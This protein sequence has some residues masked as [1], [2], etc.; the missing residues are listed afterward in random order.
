MIGLDAKNRRTVLLTKLKNSSEPLTGTALARDLGVSR[1]VIVGD[2]AILRA[3]GID[4]YATPQGYI[5][6]QPRPH[7]A[8][9]AKLACRHGRD[10]LAEELTIIIDNGATVLD[11]IVEHP[12]YGELKANLML[13][14][15]RELADFL[16]KIDQGAEPL[17]AITGGVHLHTVEV[18][19]QE[20]LAKIEAELRAEGI[21]M[22]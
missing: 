9:V 11:V 10:K 22:D 13:A 16:Q 4:I 12:I 8:V 7:G 14:S 20:V 2:V 3:A 6:P 19:S 1:Q 5:L 18:P 15:R 17:S 21:L